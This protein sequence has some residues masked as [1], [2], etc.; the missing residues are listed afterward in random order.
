MNEQGSEEQAKNGQKKM[1]NKFSKKLFAYD[2]VLTCIF[3]AGEGGYE[4][5]FQNVMSQAEN[6]LNENLVIQADGNAGPETIPIRFSISKI[7]EVEMG[8]VI[9]AGDSGILL[10]PE[11]ALK[12]LY[13]EKK[14]PVVLPASPDL[15]Q[16]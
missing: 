14:V 7:S 6:M 3:P 10:M 9:K 15:P 2:F 4:S 11:E 5:V 1:E 12:K 8:A 16:N 13:K